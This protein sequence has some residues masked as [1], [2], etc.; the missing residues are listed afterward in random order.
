[1]FRIRQL[2]DGSLPRDRRDLEE[3]VAIL[4]ERLP[5]IP[6][7]DLEKLPETLRDPMSARFR[8]L[9]FVAD[10][11]KGDLKGFALVLHAPDL[12][13]CLLD[14]LATGGK[15]AGSGIGGALYQRARQAARATGSVGLFFECLPDDPA[16]CSKP[17]FAR[18]NAA[19]LRFY[20]R[21]GARPIV[22]TAYESP[23][24][25]GDLDM[26]H[27]VFDDLGS[28]QALSR[29]RCRA[30]VRA[31]LERKYPHLCPPP[32][33]EK[34][35][36]SIN[37]D[38]VVLRAPR[39]TPKPASK[40][41]QA[42]IRTGESLIALI[43]NDR[44][45]IHHVRERGYVEAP[46]RVASILKGIEPTGLFWRIEPVQHP[47]ACIKAVHDPAFVEYLKR[48]C[49]GL[50]ESKSVYPYVFPIRNRAR[51]PKDAAYAAGYYCIDTFTPLN[52]NAYLAARRAVDCVMTGADVL[53]NGHS[54]AYA[55]VRPPGHHAERGSF[56]GFCYFC[57]C[58][59]GAHHLAAHGRVAILDIDYHHGNG[60]Q[61]IFYSRADVLT[62]SIHGHPSIAYPFFTGFPEETGRDAGE[63]FNL[64]IALPE[65]IEPRQYH[66]ALASALARIR[67]FDPR[68]L[69][70]SV[71]FD[72][73][74]GDPTGTWPLKPDDFSRIGGSIGTL[75]LPTLL[76]Q[77]GGYRT[78]SLGAN[79]AAFF[80]GLSNTLTNTQTNTQSSPQTSPQT[81]TP[82]S[83][84]TPRG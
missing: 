6:E 21:Y 43:V 20:E 45:D 72:T 50:T 44:H 17:E 84:N 38:P 9:L 33:V 22:N 39:Y 47:E 46:A 65:Q 32:Y 69:V 10:D 71:G 64:N 48:V 77:E 56:G 62:I 16:S 73:G 60:Q 34:V 53:L 8:A 23:L 76:V 26:P 49:A 14:Y 12:G 3:I 63:G 67:R 13:F 37:D 82:P 19:R 57:N 35:V 42:S 83:P 41:K 15:L 80:T 25:P 54:A 68:F 74:K 7:R 2:V 4:R 29:D 61:D 27:L 75:G 24:N 66:D 1:M 78:L 59:V 31:I 40:P 28:G 70:V 52:K 5:G 11:L 51:P 30:I 55:L 79:A 18:A 36:A 81:G 58:A